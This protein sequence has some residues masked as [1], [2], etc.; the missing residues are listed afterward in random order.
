MNVEGVRGIIG[1]R[2]ANPKRIAEVLNE[3]STIP[4]GGGMVS[5]AID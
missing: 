3:L 4:R 1:V 2:A 5:G